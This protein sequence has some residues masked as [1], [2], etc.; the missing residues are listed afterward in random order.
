MSTP[1]QIDANRA[2]AREST[3]PRTG[4][5]KSRTSR[6]ARR[7]GLSIPVEADPALSTELDELVQRL[8]GN[9][10]DADVVAQAQAFA[11]ATIDL[12]RI[13][14]A[15]VEATRRIL[16]LG[17][18][19][20]GVEDRANGGPALAVDRAMGN[21]AMDNAPVDNAAMDN[22]VMGKAAAD[23]AAV[24]AAIRQ[25]AKLDRYE[26]RAR[27]RRRAAARAFTDRFIA[28]VQRQGRRTLAFHE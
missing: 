17:T 6:N 12:A 14:R 23:G 27:A 15:R 21:T 7:H 13:K 8:V 20:A 25:L 2:N 5:G 19:S 26:R 24:A 11:E 10:V 16:A 22:A 28:A 3:G 1:R 9:H 18:P 4:A